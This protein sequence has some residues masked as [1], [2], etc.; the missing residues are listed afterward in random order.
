MR[1]LLDRVCRYRYVVL[2]LV[3][4]VMWVD[5]IAEGGAYGQ[6]WHYFLTGAG[7]LTGS[8]GLHVYARL[9]YLQFGP[10]ALLVT[11]PLRYLGPL[12]G[13]YVVSALGMA[14]GV[15]TIRIVE[16]AAEAMLDEP[17]RQALP[18]AVVVGGVFVLAGWTS[19]AVARGHPD[20]VLALLGVALA[21]RATTRRRWLLAAVLLGLAAAVKP[22][23]LFALPLAA[24]NPRARWRGPIVAVAAAVLPWVPFFLAD[25]ST[26]RV[27]T[28]HLPVSAMS[29]LHAL[30]LAVG[31][32][33]AWPRE[34]QFAAAVLLGALAVQAGK[35][36]LVPMI[37]CAVRVNLDP[38]T[39]D[40]YGTGVVLGAFLWD[41]AT[42]AR[43][44]ALRTMLSWLALFYLF[45][46]VYYLRLPATPYRWLVVGARLL[47]LAAPVAVTA[48]VIR[49]RAPIPG[50]A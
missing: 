25:S 26:W 48:R 20:D 39:V 27:E 34:A 11:V 45:D 15:L 38:A 30:G 4:A 33:P 28:F 7:A 18:L 12:H 47:V 10:L 16:R 17:G 24:A 42:P 1:E 22:W 14:A 13:W 29:T 35:W 5:A 6:D 8:A 43:V 49:R 41:L 37:A 3:A 32:T 40:T 2:V 31:A 9:P 36:Y 19:A 44:P 50:P 23:A 46:D 21:V